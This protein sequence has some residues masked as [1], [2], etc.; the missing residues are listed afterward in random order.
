MSKLSLGVGAPVGK[1]VGKG[2]HDRYAGKSGLGIGDLGL[3]GVGGLGL[4]GVRGTGVGG[5]GV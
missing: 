2:S 1:G 3:F 5:C 4:F